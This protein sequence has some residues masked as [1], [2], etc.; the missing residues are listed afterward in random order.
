MNRLKQLENK[1]VPGAVYR[2]GDLN[3][4]SKSVDRHLQALVAKGSLKKVRAGTYYC[5]KKSSFGDVPAGDYELVKSFLKDDTFLITSPNAYNKLGLGTTQLYNKYC[6]YNNKRHG[7]F[8]LGNRKFEF[9][10]K[11]GFPSEVTEEFLFIDLMNNLT[12]LAENEEQVKKK[13]KEKIKELDEKLLRDLS[14]SFGKVATKKF[15]QEALVSL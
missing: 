11:A 4:W 5:P 6:V 13:A 12:T 8:E 15:V 14:N 9:K 2:R 7:V 10:R 3:K 1:L